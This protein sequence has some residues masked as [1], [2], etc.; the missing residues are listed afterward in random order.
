MKVKIFRCEYLQTTDI[1]K[2]INDFVQKSNVHV[3]DI[4]ISESM[5]EEDYSYTALVIYEEV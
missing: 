1:E 2:E 5:W 4:K 3:V